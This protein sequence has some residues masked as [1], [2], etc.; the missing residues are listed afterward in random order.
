MSAAIPELG[1]FGTR[2]GVRVSAIGEDGDMVIL[3]HVE[4]RRALAAFNSYCRVVIGLTDIYDGLVGTPVPMALKAI[5]HGWASLVTACDEAGE[6]DHEEDCYQCIEI[7]ESLWW[8]E[9]GE[10][11]RPNAFPVTYFIA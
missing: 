7:S 4:P 6:E 8:M 5:S 11:E 10:K 1:G 3:G 9:I 2:Y